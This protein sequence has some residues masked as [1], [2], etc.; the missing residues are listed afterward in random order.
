MISFVYFA[1]RSPICSKRVPAL[2]QLD[3]P[4]LT[5]V[6]HGRPSR[7]NRSFMCGALGEKRP[8]E[9]ELDFARSL[10]LRTLEHFPAERLATSCLPWQLDA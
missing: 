9:E 10:L 1:K 4:V 5:E 3:E 2:V 6:V 7:G 8:V